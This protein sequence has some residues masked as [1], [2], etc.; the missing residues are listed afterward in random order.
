MSKSATYSLLL[1]IKALSRLL[2]RVD[3]RWLGDVPGDPW[4]NVRL[5]A[6]LNHTSLFEPLYAGG[7]PNRFLRDVARRGLVP[8]ARKTTVRPFVG[9][10]FTRVAKNVVPVTRERDGT[11]EA[12]LDRIDPDRTMV[13]MLPE[14]RMKRRTGLDAHGHPLTVRGGIADVIRR[15]SSGRMIIAYSGGLHHV[16]APGDRFPRVFRR[17][18]MRLESLDLEVYRNELLERAGPEGFKRAVVED[19]TRRRDRF[20]PGDLTPASTRPGRSAGSPRGLS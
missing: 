9:R 11:W 15:L 12:F 6:I 4:A 1:A 13:L 8:V 5:V 2:Y 7:V 17:L 3:M 18:T 19:L 16:Q 20:C 14:G 10:F